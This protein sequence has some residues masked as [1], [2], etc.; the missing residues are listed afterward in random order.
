MVLLYS[1]PNHE[2]LTTF[3]IN[4]LEFLDELLTM[5]QCED[6]VLEEIRLFT[7][8]ALAAQSQDRCRWSVLTVI[9]ARAHCGIL[10]SLM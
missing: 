2:D 3:F 7:V 9:S 10:H 1:N 8:L 6:I 4:E 5:L